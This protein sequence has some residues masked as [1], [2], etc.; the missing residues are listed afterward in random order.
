MSEPSHIQTR[1]ALAPARP[2]GFTLIEMAV[3]LGIVGVLAALGYQALGVLQRRTVVATALN[4]VTAQ[5][6][7]LRVQALARGAPA[8]FVIDPQRGLYWSLIDRDSDFD[9]ELF[10]ADPRYD[11][12]DDADL[13]LASGEL[14]SEIDFVRPPSTDPLPAPYQAL[15]TGADCSFCETVGSTR[16]GV[17][18]FQT[19]GRVRVSGDEALAAAGGTFTLRREHKGAI[20]HLTLGVVAQTGALMRL[21]WKE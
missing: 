19:D 12:A 2:R 15:P 10:A 9:P 6:R 7:D 1:S 8:V 20:E 21:E 17:F 13:I 18:V 14:P 4:D 3:V 11:E 16:L 5:V